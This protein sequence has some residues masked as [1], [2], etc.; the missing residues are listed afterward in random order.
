MKTRFMLLCAIGIITS[1]GA[2]AQSLPMKLIQ[3]IPMPNVEGYFD[4]PAVDVKGER[5]FAPGEHQR[6]H[7]QRSGKGRPNA[8]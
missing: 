7:A 5:L 4:H 1:V 8:F 2:C 6:T 3:T